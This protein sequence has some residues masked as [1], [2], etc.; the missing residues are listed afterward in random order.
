MRILRGLSSK[1]LACG[2]IAGVYETYDGHVVTVIDAL[3]A[4]CAEGH[5]AGNV[6][7]AETDA[8]QPAP[9]RSTSSDPR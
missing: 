2:C 4:S 1:L 3:A 5:T 6:I 8:M 9:V 7:P